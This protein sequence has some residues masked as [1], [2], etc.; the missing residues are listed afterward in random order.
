MITIEATAPGAHE[1]AGVLLIKVGSCSI[2]ANRFTESNGGTHWVWALESKCPI[3]Q[4][5][6][7]QMITQNFDLGLLNVV[8]SEVIRKLDMLGKAQA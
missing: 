3:L 6:E 4:V 2:R 8:S 1:Q 7:M 5:M